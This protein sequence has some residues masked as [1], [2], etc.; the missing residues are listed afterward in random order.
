MFELEKNIPGTLPGQGTFVAAFGQANEGDSSPNTKGMLLYLGFFILTH[1]LINSYLML[2]YFY[3]LFFMYF[4]S[5][6]SCPDGTPC[7]FEHSTC[8][9]RNE[10][11][12]FY[13]LKRV[14]WYFE[15]G[16]MVL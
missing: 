3:A 6:A 16:C 13:S 1:I 14:V 8:G 5:G 2:S 9:G 12:L 4:A 7:D 11:S 15:E 10:G